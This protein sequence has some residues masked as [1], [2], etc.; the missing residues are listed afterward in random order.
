ML[1]RATACARFVDSWR[2]WVALGQLNLGDPYP[3]IIHQL[4]GNKNAT[5][6]TAWKTLE[7]AMY[8]YEKSQ[9][10][11]PILNKVW[12][13]TVGSGFESQQSVFSH[14]GI[15]VV[16]VCLVWIIQQA[17]MFIPFIP[18]NSEKMP[19]WQQHDEH[20]SCKGFL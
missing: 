2:P 15:I 5:H 7:T 1:Y 8:H 12:G 13:S 11:A 16:R 19:C 14:R 10:S 9:P 3:Y 6:K 4:P 17:A 20:L 18:T